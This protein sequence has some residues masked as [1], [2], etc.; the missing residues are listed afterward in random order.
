[1]NRRH[2]LLFLLLVCA[3]AVYQWRQKAEILSRETAL[4]AELLQLKNLGEKATAPIVGAVAL[5]ASPSL[6]TA[7]DFDPDKFVAALIRLVPLMRDARTQ[8]PAEGGEIQQQAMSLMSQIGYAPTELLKQAYKKLMSSSL[9]A[10]E[11]DELSQPFLIRLAESEPVWAAARAVKMV[12]HPHILRNLIEVWAPHDTVAAKAWI[13]AAK[14][15]G[16][17]AGYDKNIVETLMNNVASAQASSDPMG[18]LRELPGLNPEA[19]RQSVTRMAGSLKTTDQR[20]A[21]LERIAGGDQVTDL[22]VLTLRHFANALGEYAGFEASRAALD[23]AKL[24]PQMRDATAAIIAATGIGPET[25]ARANW[26]LENRRSEDP[27][28][29]ASFIHTWTKADFNGAA[30]WMKTQ[31]AGPQRDT[32]IVAFATEVASA[33]PPSA[34]DW[35]NTINDSAQRTATLNQIW[36]AWHATAPDEAAAYF[37]KNGLTVPE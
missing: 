16:S 19:Q 21:A 14:Q 22:N 27:E 23:S 26:L 24:S 5:P 8:A 35:A 36:K 32:A 13:E 1:M 18:A 2:L 10:E 37:Q 31:P 9:T 7:A 11:K 3:A 4:R 12:N 17:L 33:E 6:R 28:P 25:A 30:N 20:R 34:V 15:N 29:F